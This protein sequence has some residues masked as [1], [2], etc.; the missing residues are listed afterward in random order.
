MEPLLGDGSLLWGR[1]L[2][3]GV[4]VGVFP[5]SVFPEVEEDAFPGLGEALLG[6]WATFAPTGMAE[7]LDPVCLLA[8]LEGLELGL[9]LIPETAG[10]LLVDLLPLPTVRRVVVEG[11]VGVVLER[12]GVLVEVRPDLALTGRNPLVDLLSRSEI[13]A[14]RKYNH[15]HY[16]F[17]PFSSTGYIAPVP[18]L[19]LR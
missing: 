9:V 2:A 3:P 16:G 18:K 17:S 14:E 12:A 15:S 8:P 10:I 19:Q 6:L 5:V 11:L 1:T 4:A 7:G 13:G